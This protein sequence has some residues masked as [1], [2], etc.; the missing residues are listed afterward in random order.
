[1]DVTPD[2]DVGAR[3]LEIE[4][5]P[6][7]WLE[8]GDRLKAAADLVGSRFQS[9]M[10]SLMGIWDALPAHM[11]FNASR[12]GAPALLLIGYAIEV[13]AKGL[14]V[15]ADPQEAGRLKRHIDHEL[16]S[17][18]GV[19]LEPG[20]EALI[21][22]LYHCVKWMGRYPTPVEKDGQRFDEAAARAG[23]WMFGPGAIGSD[24]Y[25]RSVVLFDRMRNRLEK[26]I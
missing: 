12:L 11:Q 1:M 18:A 2:D 21:E 16:L 13:L 17:A 26:A 3:I 9:E 7:A 19:E 20:D 8:E 22:K 10:Q 25:R 15:A 23:H 5:N 24:D 14:I 4:R 6:R